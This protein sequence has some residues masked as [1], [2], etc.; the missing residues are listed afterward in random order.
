MALGPSNEERFEEFVAT[1][2]R[3]LL[4]FAYLVIG[5]RDDAEDAVQEAL[6][7]VSRRWEKVRSETALAYVR[8]AVLNKAV[9]IRR[10]R[11]ESALRAADA[12][13]VD[14][15][16]LRFEEDQA[17]FQRLQELPTRQRAALVLRYFYDLPD[18][19]VAAQLNCSAQTVRSQIH[20]GLAKLRTEAA[21]REGDRHDA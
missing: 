2:R 8:R 16:L 12:H 14:A 19:E 9:E 13:G 3:T 4:R 10:R 7:S 5:N 21:S 6:I 11:P 1:H 18:S 15:A 20:R 17:F